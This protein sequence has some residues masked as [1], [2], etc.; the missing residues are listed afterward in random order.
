MASCKCKLCA[1]TLNTKTAYKVVEKGRN[2]YYCSYD[3]Y[4]QFLKNKSSR[5][6]LINLIYDL[7]DIKFKDG[8]SFIN[9]RLKELNDSYSY[10]QIYKVTDEMSLDIQFAIDKLTNNAHK[11]NYMFAMIKN[12]LFTLDDVQEQYK[13]ETMETI[14]VEDINVEQAMDLQVKRRKPVE[15]KI[16]QNIPQEIDFEIDF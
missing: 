4:E 5:I 1:K 7:L 13:Q 6:N 9:T 10:E 12:K 2:I 11:I 8:G 15:Q 14:K 3:H 16:N